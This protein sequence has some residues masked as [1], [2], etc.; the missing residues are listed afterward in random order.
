MINISDN[1]FELLKD[2]IQKISGIAIPKEKQ[3]LFA[4]RLSNLLGEIGCTNFS[5]FYFRLTQQ[6][7]AHLRNC[8]V[9]AMT[10]K[11]TGFFRDEHPFRTL[12]ERILPEL[13]EQ[14]ARVSAYM[15]P[16]IR[17]WSV[18]CSTGEEPY[19]VAM[20]VREWLDTQDRFTLR[21][22]SVV[23][24]DISRPALKQAK[25]ALFDE[26][27]ISAKVP[28]TYQKKY[29]S[30]VNGQYRVN[31][32]IR[33]M[34]VFSELNLNNAFEQMG[35]F[36]LILCRNVIIYFDRALKKKIINGF[37][38][39]LEPAGVLMMGASENLYNIS[40]RFEA[41]HSGPTIYYRKEIQARGGK[42]EGKQR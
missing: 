17:I 7:D 36:N 6:K 16:R 40:D 9:D 14:Q 2:Y 41:V 34:V 33:A 26:R 22:V 30:E 19:S 28:F 15:Q 42:G 12:V 3:Y 23:A 8:L 21:D 13:G 10:T 11:E 27:R 39:M 38:E 24:S 25:Q 4:T 20:S 5:E 29:F 1:E 35:S 18:G 32:D 31:G 37:Y